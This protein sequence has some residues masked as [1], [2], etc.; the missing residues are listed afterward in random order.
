M[1]TKI[2]WHCYRSAEGDAP[3]MEAHEWLR[4]P[5]GRIRKTF[6]IHNEVRLWMLDAYAEHAPEILRPASVS[7]G[8]ARGRALESLKNGQ[9]VVWLEFRQGLP[10]LVIAA[11]CCPDERGLPCPLD[12][13]EQPQTS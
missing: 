11:I 2:H 6:Y 8:A 4:Q 9:H 3:D 7:D 13:E 12:R 5:A 10:P 1:D